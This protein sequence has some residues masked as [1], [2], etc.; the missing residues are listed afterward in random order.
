MKAVLL[1]TL[2]LAAATGC[3]RYYENSEPSLIV[4]SSTKETCSCIFVLRK[5]EE[6]CKDYS[7]LIGPRQIVF[8]EINRDR[9]TVEGS[10]IAW[11]ARARFISREQGCVLEVP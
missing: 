4:N 9:G 5:G 1:G 11:R 3:A 10:L 8:F 7:R 6:E 2:L